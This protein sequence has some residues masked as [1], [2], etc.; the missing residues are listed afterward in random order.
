LILI[1]GFAL[2]DGN[3]GGEVNGVNGVDG[4]A[5]GLAGGEPLG[6]LKQQ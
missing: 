5:H 3:V 1:N 2:I 4:F 6:P